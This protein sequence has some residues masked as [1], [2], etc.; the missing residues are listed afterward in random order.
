MPA[1]EPFPWL[2]LDGRSDLPAHVYARIDDPAERLV[3]R[4]FDACESPEKRK[5]TDRLLRRG[6][7][8]ALRGTT[9]YSLLNRLVSNRLSRLTG[10]DN[11]AKKMQLISAH[12][13]GLAYIRYVFK[14]EPIASMEYDELV[15][16]SVPVIRYY[17]AGATESEIAS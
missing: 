6:A 14:I 11:R 3:R 16:L 1:T 13:L 4:F 2:D 8:S 7:R 5:R 12:L 9:R 17:L 10:I 15:E